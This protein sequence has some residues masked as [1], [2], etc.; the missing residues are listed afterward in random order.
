MSEDKVVLPDEIERV[1]LLEI[2]PGDVLVF[3][4]KEALSQERHEQLRAHLVRWGQQAGLEH[5]KM[6]ILG[7]DVSL[8][9]LRAE[10]I[11]GGSDYIPQAVRAEIMALMPM[12]QSRTVQAVL[13]AKQ[14]GGGHA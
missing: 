10:M 3:Q 7:P 9:I 5:L 11:G 4:T 8:E 2:K 12:I 6:M 14:R 1:K 13:D